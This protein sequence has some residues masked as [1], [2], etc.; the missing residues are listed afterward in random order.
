MRLLIDN[1]VPRKF[2]KLIPGHEITHARQLGWH[3]LQNG[4]LIAA[5]E[6]E[7]FDAILTT[8]K[9]LKSQQNLRYRR[10]SIIVLSPRLVFY[11]QLAPLAGKLILVLDNLENG[12][13]VVIKP[14]EEA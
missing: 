14:D 3:E 5:A 12:A 2:A 7:G 9:N 8:D 11:D 10:L 6:A 1:C 4:L 13:F